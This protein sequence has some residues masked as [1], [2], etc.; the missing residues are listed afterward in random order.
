MNN[1]FDDYIKE[2]KKY[3]LHPYIDKNK[4]INEHI[5]LYGPNGIG[6]YTQALKYI[7]EYSPTNCKY[8]KKPFP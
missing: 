4:F 6:K 7:K 1:R 2:V 8:E 3:D 5:I